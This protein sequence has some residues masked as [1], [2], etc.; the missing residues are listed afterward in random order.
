M[1]LDAEQ[2]QSLAEACELFQNQMTQEALSYL[3]GR[4]IDSATSREFSLGLVGEEV[5]PE[6]RAYRGR[7]AIPVLKR[8]GCTGFSFRCIEN[9]SCKEEGHPKYLTKG[10]QQ[11][12][13]TKDLENHDRVIA[14]S[15]GQFDCI[16]LSGVLGIPC[17]GVPGVQSWKSHPWWVSLFS[18][19]RRVLLFADN[20]SGKQRNYGSELG[21]AILS[22]LPQCEVLHLPEPEEGKDKVDVTDAFLTYGPEYLLNLAGM[23]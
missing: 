19:F 13:N 22:S 6:Y 20:D 8:I 17:C 10:P 12:F 9:H 16:I 3:N 14:I 1:R 11:L 21:E 7:I 4:G 23:S 18:G 2:R 5:P 15:E